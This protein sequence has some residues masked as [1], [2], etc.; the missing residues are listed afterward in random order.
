M[1]IDS[2]KQFKWE[3]RQASSSGAAAW[4]PTEDASGKTGKLELIQKETHKF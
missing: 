4:D 3:L 2:S 1:A